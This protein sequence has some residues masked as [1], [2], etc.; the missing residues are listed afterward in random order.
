[1]GYDSLMSHYQ[2]NETQYVLKIFTVGFANIIQ[3]AIFNSFLFGYAAKN[4]RMKEFMQFMIFLEGVAVL[5]GFFNARFM[6]KVD[7]RWRILS[8][9]I[10]EVL[11][12]AAFISTYFVISQITLDV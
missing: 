10:V 12:W 6:L 9:T 4:G 3:K 1:M 7:I 2:A 11:N 5:A 8:Y